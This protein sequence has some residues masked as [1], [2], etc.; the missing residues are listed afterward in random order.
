MFKVAGRK[1]TMERFDFQMKSHRTL[2]LLHFAIYQLPSTICLS[3]G[4]TGSAL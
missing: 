4:A 2:N 1:E 3:S